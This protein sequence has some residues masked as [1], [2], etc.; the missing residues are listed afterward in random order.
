M[1]LDFLRLLTFAGGWVLAFSIA[2]SAFG[3]DFYNGKS[4][5]FIVGTAPGGGFDTYARITARHIGKHIP[6]NPTRA[7]DAC[8]RILRTQL[9]PLAL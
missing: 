9:R 5:L 2:H 4:L 8:G 7:Q 1:S 3:Q 6:G